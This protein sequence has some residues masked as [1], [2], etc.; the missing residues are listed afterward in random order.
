MHNVASVFI[1][2]FLNLK[3][4]LTSAQ[5]A[6]HAN[7]LIYLFIFFSVGPLQTDEKLNKCNH[8][9]DSM[10]LGMSCSQMDSAA[11]VY[12]NARFGPSNQMLS[13]QKKEENI[14]TESWDHL[15]FDE[16][17]KTIDCKW[18]TMSTMAKIERKN[19]PQ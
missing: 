15:Y 14:N 9:I 7:S 12:D 10:I 11:M 8:S 13:A 3:L 18:K 2:I 4:E 5:K 19:E 1:I 6:H 17:K 16:R